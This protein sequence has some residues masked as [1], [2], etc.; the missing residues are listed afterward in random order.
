MKI[1]VAHPSSG[2]LEREAGRSV[3]LMWLTEGL[4]PEHKTIADFRKDHAPAIQQACA[5]FVMLCRELGL[6]SK[7]IVAVDEHNEQPAPQPWLIVKTRCRR[8]RLGPRRL[9]KPLC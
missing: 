8:N 4:A 9:A 7:A 5:Q 6:F 2:R 1:V 3:E